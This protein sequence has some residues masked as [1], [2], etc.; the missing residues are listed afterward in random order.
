[1]ID[2]HNTAQIFSGFVVACAAFLLILRA[3]MRKRVAARA[4]PKRELS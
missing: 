1:M 2:L 3:W 4:V